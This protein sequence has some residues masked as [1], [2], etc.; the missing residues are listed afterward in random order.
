MAGL[1]SIV[2]I[3]KNI[4][5]VDLQPLRDEALRLVKV[6][7]VGAAGVGR[8]TLA[9]AMRHDPQRPDA[10]SQT[11]ILITD[12]ETPTGVAYADLIILMV[13][14]TRANFQAEQAAERRWRDMGKKVLVFCNKVDALEE[15]QV[16]RQWIGREGERMLYGSAAD[17]KFLE[18]IFVPVVLE[19]LPEMH[20]ALGRQFPLFRLAIARQ[21][22]NETCFSN[23][24]YALSTGLA[25]AIPSLDL[26][27]NVADMIVLTKSQAFLVYKLGLI[28]GFSTQ[29]QDYVAEF[30]G[31]IGGGFLWRQ[32]ARQLVGLIPVYGI[33]PK[34][35]VAYA[36]TFVV[37]N[38]VL[39]WYLTGKHVTRQQVSELYRQAF[40]RG[41]TAARQLLER[42]RP[43]RQGKDAATALPQPG[44]DIPELAGGRATLQGLPA[45]EAGAL[46][47]SVDGETP[48][49]EKAKAPAARKALFGRGQRRQKTCPRCH[50]ASAADAQFCQYCGDPLP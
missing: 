4:G 13:D 22:I 31:V 24:A 16:L 1:K 5:E 23:A 36:G 9:E 34:V 41:K 11:P 10:S 6:A 26:P 48:P 3:W 2:N 14:A 37:G 20:L 40:A 21:L 28:V 45:P 42:V 19:M 47:I 46:A 15:G 17:R 29:W 43:R 25:E 49:A 35:A 32:L 38:A 39:Q 30:G 18:R 7:I 27:L 44:K 33:V 8:H 12:V 50:K